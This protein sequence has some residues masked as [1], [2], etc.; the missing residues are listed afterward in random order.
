[1][2]ILPSLAYI[3]AHD[4]R[5]IDYQTKGVYLSKS[6]PDRYVALRSELSPLAGARIF[7]GGG[8]SERRRILPRVQRKAQF[9]GE[10]PPCEL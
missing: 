4:K 9:V 5:S 10:A 6:L 7:G 2:A 1:M 3:A 8:S